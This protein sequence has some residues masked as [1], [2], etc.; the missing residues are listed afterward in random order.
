M[1]IKKDADKGFYTVKKDDI[2]GLFVKFFITA[3]DAGAL[4]SMWIMEFEPSGY[5]KMHS[6]KE[7]HYLYVIEG[8]CTVIKPGYKDAFAEKGDCVFIASCEEH[9]IRNSG[10][11]PLKMLS[12]M[13]VLKVATGRSTTPCG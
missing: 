2:K 13:P 5:A 3:N 11:S 12:V 8:V 6:H 1:I 4:N 7:E 10:D 9:E